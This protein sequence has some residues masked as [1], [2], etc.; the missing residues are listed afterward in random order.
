[1]SDTLVWT[2]APSGER[3][4]EDPS[5]AGDAYGGRDIK[6]YPWDVE[7]RTAQFRPFAQVVPVGTTDTFRVDFVPDR[8]LVAVVPAANVLAYVYAGEAPS[9]PGIPLAGGGSVKGLPGNVM[10]GA[11]TFRNAGTNPLLIVAFAL[12]GLPDFDYSPGELA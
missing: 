2:P 6:P 12:Y 3:P 5:W 10:T 1:M 9:G 4:Q 7:A 11:L 8:W